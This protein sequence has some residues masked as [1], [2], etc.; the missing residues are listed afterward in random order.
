MTK[1]NDAFAAVVNEG[2]VLG[3]FPEGAGSN[4]RQLLPFYSSLFKPA[5]VGR[6]PVSAARI[7]YTLAGGSVENDICY[8]GDMSFLPHFLRL[9]A[10]EK[11]GVTVTYGPVLPPGLDRK[12]MARQLHRQVSEL[13]GP[14]PVAA[15][16]R[17]DASCSL[18]CRTLR[19][20]TGASTGLAFLN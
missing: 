10:R 14:H 17:A 6:W 16:A 20:A 18:W 4:G 11:M 9:L 5:V 7:D 19:S 2:V 15:G 3:L 8:W 13:A 1:F 12:Q